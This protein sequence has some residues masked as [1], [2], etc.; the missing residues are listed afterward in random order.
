M[1]AIAVAVLA[2]FLVVRHTRTE[3]E[4][5]RL[6]L[7]GATVVGRQAPLTAALLVTAGACLVAG[8]GTTLGL[9]AVGLPV[10]APWSSARARMSRARVRGRGRL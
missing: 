4:T 8:V 3:E 7:L 10:R 6:E 5:G 2:L 1:G 9:I